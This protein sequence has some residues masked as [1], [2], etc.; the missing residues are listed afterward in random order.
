MSQDYAIIAAGGSGG[1][2]YPALSIA[3]ALEKKD[4]DLEIL[5]V[6][7]AGGMENEII[8][9]RGYKLLHLPIG[10]L[11]R[12]VGLM[13]RIKTLFLLPFALLKAFWLCQ[14]YKPVFLLGVGGHAS[15]PMLLAGAL[16]RYYTVIWEPN[17]MPGLANRLLAKF[18]DHGVVI[19]EKAREMLSLRSSTQLGYPVRESIERLAAN[20]QSNQVGLGEK[21]KVL[22][23][24]GSLG[25]KSI[26]ELLPLL[27]K[28]EPVL[29]EKVELIHQTGKRH[30]EDVIQFY[31]E[32]GVSG[33][34]SVVPY[35]DDVEAKLDWADVVIC[36]AGAGTLSEVSAAGKPCILIPF[37]YASDDHQKKN[38]L[39]FSEKG[40]GVMI[41]EK[42]LTQQKIFE[43]LLDLKSN[44]KK[45]LDMAKASFQLHIPHSA[46]RIAELLLEEDD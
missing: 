38:A 26:N 31:E 4:P 8:P 23:F 27:Y 5:F 2:I 18:V 12:S 32:L 36:R 34:C 37:P 35:I 13:E 22:V 42:D 16:M 20:H 21:L 11:H 19:Y 33:Q 15:G 6:G 39:I 1:H 24:M 7:T 45:R 46:D 41:E 28:S 14:K 17:A 29:S 10:R 43:T 9:K 44:P 40:A 25:A 30:F 3:E